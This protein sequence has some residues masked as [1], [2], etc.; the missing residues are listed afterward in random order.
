MS[1]FKVDDQL[2]FNAKVVERSPRGY[3]PFGSGS[4]SWLQL[5]SQMDSIHEHRQTL[6]HAVGKRCVPFHLL[7]AGLWDEVRRWVPVP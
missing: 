2:A 6:W 7:N 5:N 4:R 3:E 1:W